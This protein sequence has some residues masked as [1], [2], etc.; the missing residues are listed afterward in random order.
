LESSNGKIIFRKVD[1]EE[2]QIKCLFELLNKRV[3]NISHSKA[4]SYEEHRQ[5]VL[6]HPYRFWYIV[7]KDGFPVGTCYVMDNNSVS[8]FLVDG[9]ETCL[10]NVVHFIL[11]NHSPL[12]DVKSVRPAHF[13][14]NVPAENTDMKER[15][16][17]MG[18]K[19]IQTTFSLS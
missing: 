1:G 16:S 7:V 2:E 5:F 4:P 14:I 13:Y 6:N 3:H 18:W 19:E 12:E 15:I 17:N 8:A 9:E 11:S 10:E